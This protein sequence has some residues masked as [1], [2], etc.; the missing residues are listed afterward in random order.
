MEHM[1]RPRG[2]AVAIRKLP[3]PESFRVTALHSASWFAGAVGGEKQSWGL[4]SEGHLLGWRAESHVWLPSLGL[5]GRGLGEGRDKKKTKSAKE[6]LAPT[7]LFSWR[8]TV[9]KGGTAEC[10]LYT[11]YS[12]HQLCG[13][14]QVNL[15]QPLSSFC[16][17]GIKIITNYLIG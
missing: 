7:A 14:E 16:M 13:L 4:R 17:L 10:R 6:S 12:T 1:L 3:S 5:W 15:S 11:A 8:G 9:T 2:S